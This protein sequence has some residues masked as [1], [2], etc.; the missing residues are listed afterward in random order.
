MILL[1]FTT[2]FAKC[3]G[4]FINPFTDI[5]WSCLFPLTV[6]GV[7]VTP[8]TDYEDHTA[9]GLP[10]ICTCPGIPPKIGI[11]VT[12]WEPV[13]LIDVTRTP[14]CLVGLGG[15]SMGATT[16]KK[17]GTVHTKTFDTTRS[18]FYQVHWYIYP[19]IYWLELL[20]DFACLEKR[21][22]DIAYL[23]E[24][25]PTW[26]DDEWSFLQHPE[27]G[28]FTSK[29]V[30][31][32]C[33]FDCMTSSFSDRP[34]NRYFWSAGCLGSLY[35]FTGFVEHH[36]GAVQASALLVM[37]LIAKFH[38]LKLLE[39]YA[40]TPCFHDKTYNPWLEKTLYKIHLVYPVSVACEPLGKS[41]A[42]WGSGKSFPYSGEDFVYLLWRKRRCCL[43]TPSLPTKGVF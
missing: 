7:R 3:Q 18:S 21:T 15:I 24:F 36:V 30:Q 22:I 4:K 43:G 42:L 40:N 25:D 17:H 16:V 23:S 29:L 5:S 8:G 37:R 12:F 20:T 19:L 9:H 38:R 31:L 2:L 13:R 41:D 11:K 28:V 32:A 35:P 1:W 34:S 10:F 39:S 14:Y 6:G 27:A 33:T 26:Q